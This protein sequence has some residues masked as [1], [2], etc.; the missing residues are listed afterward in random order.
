VTGT[1]LALLRFR[2]TS[3]DSKEKGALL[4]TA[5]FTNSVFLAIPIIIMF[6]GSIGVQVA[7]I[8]AIVQMILLTTLGVYI[9]AMYG[10]SRTN[11]MSLVRK[12]V[13]FPPFIATLITIPLVLLGVSIPVQLD[14]VLSVNTTMTTYVALFVVGLGLETHVPT[15]GLK[16]ALEMVCIRQVIIP[17]IFFVIIPIMPLSGFVTEVLLIQAV[18]PAAVLTVAYAQA[19]DLDAELAATTVTLGTFLVL[20]AVPFL[21]LLVG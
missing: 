8:C 2:H 18:M 17:V 21:S 10:E 14:A 5:T 3:V 13:L 6:V 12:A 4:L 1:A 7:A 19:F 15:A 20:P 9:G 11:R 16:R